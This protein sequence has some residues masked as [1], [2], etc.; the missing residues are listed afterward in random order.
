MVF[1]VDTS[2]QDSYILDTL[3]EIVLEDLR[4]NYCRIQVDD[5]TDKGDIRK[6][7]PNV[8][9]IV[10]ALIFNSP[11][12]IHGGG[13]GM[14]TTAQ[15]DGNRAS[16]TPILWK[17]LNI[18]SPTNGSADL[19]IISLDMFNQVN[20]TRAGSAIHGSGIVGGAIKLDDLPKDDIRTFG[21]ELS[22]IKNIKLHTRQQWKINNLSFG[23]NVEGF[24]NSNAYNYILDKGQFEKDHI[25]SIQDEASNYGGN[26]LA[27]FS[28]YKNY[29]NRVEASIWIQNMYRNIP[30]SKVAANP[31]AHQIDD[32]K[33]FQISYIHRGDR[34]NN[35]IQLAYF[36]ERLIYE[37]DVISTSI[38]NVHSIMINENF[39]FTNAIWKKFRFRFSYRNDIAV[40]NFY[41]ET[42]MRED[43]SAYISYRRNMNS[44]AFFINS[45]FNTLDWNKNVIDGTIFIKKD[46]NK[47]WSLDA[48]ILRNHK[49]P[50]LNDLYWPNLGNPDLKRELAH[51][52]HLNTQYKYE[53]DE[54][55]LETSLNIHY[56]MLKDK[57]QWSPNSGIWR[58]SN[59]AGVNTYGIAAVLS[60]EAPRTYQFTVKS[61]LN[62]ALN[63]SSIT[64]AINE[65][66]I[67]KE[68]T[69]SPNIKLSNITNL[70]FN[71][72]S[73]QFE[74]MYVGDRYTSSDN[75]LTVDGYWLQNLN[76][77]RLFDIGSDE[78]L[79]SLGVKNLWNK[80]YDVIPYFAMPL[81]HYFL[82]IE[83]RY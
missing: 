39:G 22:S 21:L 42:K 29:K 61:T 79:L 52:L 53:A 15:L 73:V 16:H 8:S 36:K 74:T 26:I 64:K 58:P 23:L 51:V 6:G 71:K 59:I 20:Y 10:D 31:H 27:N 19:S 83:L 17:G 43:A 41:K 46:I 63:S 38:S 12:Y 81:R 37:S 56:S 9:N 70:G 4:Y 18:Q 57:I 32:N 35:S 40:T 2:A 66:D 33:K 3:Q 60:I 47:N 30:S 78:L 44:W 82:K 65:N 77:Q 50:N 25:T 54:I 7:M 1:L 28:Y 68:L 34:F 76:F 45:R 48:S 13:P 62:L 11:L 69:Y 14:L 24:R 49:Y 72:Y 55:L 80:D 67:G 75:K 5:G